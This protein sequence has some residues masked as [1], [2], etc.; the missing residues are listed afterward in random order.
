MLGGG[1]EL[2]QK[3]SSNTLRPDSFDFDQ[4][5]EREHR[6]ILVKVDDAGQSGLL[7]GWL[8]CAGFP[9]RLGRTAR[10]RLS[11]RGDLP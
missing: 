8:E 4:N 7:L 10:V 3:R 2:E 1:T 5:Q 11:R 9:S 6:E